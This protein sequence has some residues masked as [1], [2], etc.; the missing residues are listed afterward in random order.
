MEKVNKCKYR[1]NLEAAAPV[2]LTTSVM[3]TNK[4]FKDR[5]INYAY[6]P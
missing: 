1:Q 2:T 5:A 6:C 3:Q 4:T